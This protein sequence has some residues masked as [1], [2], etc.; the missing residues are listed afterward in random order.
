MIAAVILAAGRAT[1]FGAPKVLAALEGRA[2]VRHVVDRLAAAGVDALV[3]VVG[4]EERRV[5]AVLAGTGARVVRNPAPEL[6]MSSSLRVG[7][8]A[9]PEETEAFVVALGDQPYIDV[10]VVGDLVRGWRASRPAAVVPVYSDGRGNPVLFDARMRG[11]LCELTGDAGARELL[12]Q[13]H[14]EVER[15]TIDRPAPR[16][17]DTHEDWKALGG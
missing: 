15:L 9:L 16:D 2:L 8:E 11:A 10:A 14:Q 4:D 17:V 6:G 12:A 13:H 7:V 1:R 3:V 5:A